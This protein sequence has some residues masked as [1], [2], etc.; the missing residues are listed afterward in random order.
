[1]VKPVYLDETA[2]ILFRKQTHTEKIYKIMAHIYEG[3]Q[4]DC[5]SFR[6][7]LLIAVRKTQV[8]KSQSPMLPSKCET[9]QPYNLPQPVRGETRK[10][11]D[12]A[13]KRTQQ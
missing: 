7:R 1:M 6:G 5:P 11:A 13:G 3:F 12:S 2:Q 9:Y 4:G 8:V 10:Y